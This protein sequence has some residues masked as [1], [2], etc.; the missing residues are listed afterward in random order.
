MYKVALDIGYS[1]TKITTG[2]KTFKIPTAISYAE[3]TN[4]NY[5]F[6]KVYEFEGNTYRIGEF[7][8]DE[9]FVSTDYKFIHKFAPLIVYHVLEKLQ[10]INN[11]KL[12]TDITIN[13]GLS[14]ADMKKVEEFK[15]R[16]KEIIVN[17]NKIIIK[18]I[19]ITP[20]GVGVFKDYIVNK[21][22][23]IVPT[24]SAIIDIGYNTINFLYFKGNQAI[25]SKCGA[26]PG[27]GVVSIIRPF[28][29]W[30]EANY[31]Y[32]FSEQEALN[33]FF[34]KK[35]IFNGEEQPEVVEKINSFISNFI[36]KLFNTI[37]VSEKKIL[38]TAERV[39]MGGGGCY[40]INNVRFPKNVDFVINPYEF[41]N[42]RGYFL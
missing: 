9:T 2:S 20:Q 16:I 34:D 1:S 4:I 36:N 8:V 24:S 23:G 33:I 3:D 30:L 10:L 28:T 41:S 22:G 29:K 27:H 32:S 21:N 31:G 11:G 35:F 15:Q 5:G 42:V 40:Y 12:V 7:A 38:S 18:D 6:D 37:L 13:T 14:L 39:I 26:Y 17:N 25:R 19:N